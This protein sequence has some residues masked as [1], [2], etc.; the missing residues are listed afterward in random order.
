[1]I[2]RKI[3]PLVL[4]CVGLFAGCTKKNKQEIRIRLD[5]SSTVFPIAEALAEDFQKQNKDARITVGLS[6]TGGGFKKFCAGEVEIANASRPIKASEKAD[7]EKAKPAVSYHELAIAFDGIAIAVHPS[8]TFAKTLSM[9]QLKKLWEPGSKVSL[10]SDLD[11]SWPKTKM[12]LYGPGHDSGTFDYFTEAVVGET[13]SSRS[14]F[15]ASEDDNVLVRA[16]AE[17]PSA[18]AYFG[19]AY[20]AENSSRVRALGIGDSEQTA[21]NPSIETIRNKSYILSR[22]LLIYVSGPSLVQKGTKDFLDYFF[23]HA[24]SLVSAAGYVPLTKDEYLQSQGK[25]KNL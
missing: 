7:C 6:G 25:I 10:W 20:F 9:A 17:D 8:N 5:G 12:T 24:E 4:M 1:M 11:P 15:T 14:D 22:P 13:G 21:L 19:F 3:Y 16:V 18:L 23:T 2:R